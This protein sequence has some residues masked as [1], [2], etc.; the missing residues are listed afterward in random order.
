MRMLRIFCLGIFLVSVAAACTPNGSGRSGL[1]PNVRQ[2][3]PAA[4]SRR[5]MDTAGGDPG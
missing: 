1:L 2:T 5:P 4:H 3:A